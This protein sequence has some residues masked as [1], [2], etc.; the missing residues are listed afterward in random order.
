MCRSQ[1]RQGDV[2]TLVLSGVCHYRICFFASFYLLGFLSPIFV[3]Q[4][5]GGMQGSAGQKSGSTP[6]LSVC[7]KLMCSVLPQTERKQTLL[8]AYSL[9]ISWHIFRSCTRDVQASEFFSLY[10]Y[11]HTLHQCH[12]LSPAYCSSYFD[13]CSSTSFLLPPKAPNQPQ[14]KWQYSVDY[15]L[16]LKEVDSSLL[17]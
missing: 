2:N 1:C 4:N 11:I 16:G 10:C 15:V 13:I 17:Q 7:E 8:S 12:L 9:D 6:L 5:R 14:P 3:S